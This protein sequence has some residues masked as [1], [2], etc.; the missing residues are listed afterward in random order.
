MIEYYTEFWTN[1]LDFQGRARRSAYWYA[2]LMNLIVITILSV[3]KAFVPLLTFLYGMYGLAMLIPAFSLCVRRLH[4]TGRSGFWL[5]FG[6]LPAG[7]VSLLTTFGGYS[8]IY[9]IGSH[10]ILVSLIA[11]IPLIILI[12]F[13]CQDSNFDNYYGPS[14]K[15]HQEPEPENHFFSTPQSTSTT[16]TSFYK[17]S[18]EEPKRE[19]GFYNKDKIEPKEEKRSFYK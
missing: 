19:K 1:A 12:V 3:L 10:P 14:P 13:Y 9:F 6:T 2:W 11:L 8:V 5:L 7:I 18:L 17:K 4:D 16:G 15:Y